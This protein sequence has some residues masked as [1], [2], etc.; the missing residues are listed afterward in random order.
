MKRR[1]IRIASAS[2]TVEASLSLTLFMF[3]VIL[4]SVPMELLDMQRKIQTVMEDTNRQLSQAAYISSRGIEQG[5][6]SGQ[7]N[8]DEIFEIADILAG[9]GAA[10][11]LAHRIRD[12][13]GGERI[14]SVDC[15]GSVIS[16]DGERLDLRA[17]YR[18]RL[19]FSIFALDSIPL[20]SRSLRRGWIGSEGGRF[21]MSSEEEEDRTIV[22][23]GRDSTRYHLSRDCHYISNQ[24][25]EVPVDQVG[26]YTN[27]AGK[28]YKFCSVCQRSPGSGEGGL[29][30]Y[31]AG[32]GVLSH[33]CGLLFPQL[34]CQGGPSFRGKG[35]GAVFLL[36]RGKI[37][38][39]VYS[40]ELSKRLPCACLAHKGMTDGSVRRKEK[41]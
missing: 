29:C 24:I 32:R 1:N 33:S 41:D 14:E 37:V 13:V 25:N 36:R 17:T 4:L 35:A 38:R 18:L 39:S 6:L 28:H 12:T 8:A 27:N 26:G 5:E 31:S 40:K 19:P 21:K 22:Y 7:E 23:V 3:T 2:L 10:L 11:Y 34:L 15:S 16:L 9:R 20:S 30:L